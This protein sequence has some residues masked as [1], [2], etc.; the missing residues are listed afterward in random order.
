MPSRDS[1]RRNSARSLG[2][3]FNSGAPNK[4]DQ[5]RTWARKE[6]RLEAHLSLRDQQR[7]GRTGDLLGLVNVRRDVAEEIGLCGASSYETCTELAW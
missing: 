7:E 1:R 6:D 3:I 2:V 4:R 5:F